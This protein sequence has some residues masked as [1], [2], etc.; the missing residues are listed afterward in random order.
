MI[1][2]EIPFVCLI[3]TFLVSIVF[4]CKKKIELEEN[5]YYKNILIFTLCVNATNLISHY[6]ASIYA[7]DIITPSFANTFA[8]I[9]KLGS[10]SIVIITTNLL[11]YILY[12]T[13]EKYRKNF[14]NLKKINNTFY[15]VIGVV[16]FL[17]EFEVYK[18]GG[19]TS[20]RGSTVVLT[21]ALVFIDLIIA[22]IVSLINLKKFDKRY[23]AIYIIIPLIFTLGLFVM[24]HPE[25]NIYDLILCLLCYLM[26]FTIE[27]PDLKIISQLEFAKDHAERANRAKSDFLS[28]MSHEIRTPLNAIVGLSEDNLTYKESLPQ[29]VIENSTDIINA[30]QTLLEIVGNILDINKIEANKMELVE[31]NYNFKE[32]IISMCKVTQTR[33]GEKNIVFSLNIADDIPYELIGDKAKVKEIINNLLTNAIKYTEAGEINLNIKCINNTSK[34][35]TMLMISCQDTGRG[36]KAE[37]INKLF[38]KFERLDIERNTTTEGTGLGLAITKALVEMM[39]GTINVQSQFGK[40]SIFVVNIPQKIAKL[41]KPMSEEELLD[42]ASKLYSKDLITD[43]NSRVSS[44]ICTGKKVL[45]VDDNKLNI[46]VARRALQSFNFIIDECYDG[47]ECLAKIKVGNEYDLILMDIMMPNM[48][49]ETAFAKLKENPLFKI[50]TIA[51]T[52]DALAGSKEK[53]MSLG[54]MDYLAKPFNRDQIKEKLDK[55]FNQNGTVSLNDEKVPKYDPNVDRFKDVEA[56][57]YGVS[58]ENDSKE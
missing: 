48:S 22:F 55:L 10:L 40:G 43:T 14:A 54:F 25:F 46:K 36:I 47:I 17:L 30:S 13:F 20:G 31:N 16:L 19:V 57:V 32:E 1:E 42:T 58:E 38:T 50:P 12:I 23:Y 53:Y 37:H 15:L 51:L 45:I 44:S 33:I 5:Y 18:V 28:S 34:N 6:L 9:N 24:F 3:F 4:F 27:N 21:F 7:K 29:E 39:N 56:F 2:Y 52:A 35:I 8:M 49:G 41:I 26:Y 11:S